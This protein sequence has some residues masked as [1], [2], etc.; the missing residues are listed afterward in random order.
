MLKATDEFFRGI[1]RGDSL[2]VWWDSPKLHP[3]DGYCRQGVVLLVKGSFIAVRSPAG[4]VFCIGRHHVAS[5]TKVRILNGSEAQCTGSRSRSR[6]I[7]R[8]K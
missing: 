5:G 6:R 1:Q 8:A 3:W 4:Y 7:V 2:Q